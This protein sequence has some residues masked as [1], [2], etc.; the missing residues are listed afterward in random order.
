MYPFNQAYHKVRIKTCNKS[1]LQ[2][3]QD[4]NNDLANFE[5]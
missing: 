3:I 5:A 2:K 1:D 4:I